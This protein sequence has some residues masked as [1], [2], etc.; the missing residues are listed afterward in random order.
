MLNLDAVLREL[1]DGLGVCQLGYGGRKGDEA[2]L[3][4]GL[5]VLRLFRFLTFWSKIN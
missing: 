4:C 1:S 2:Y 3:G 5:R